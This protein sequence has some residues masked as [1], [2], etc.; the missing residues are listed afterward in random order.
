[1]HARV[2]ARLTV[3]SFH[4]VF[5]FFVEETISQISV[6][7]VSA[8]R[9]DEPSARAWVTRS[10]TSHSHVTSRTDGGLMYPCMPL[11]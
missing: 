1:M 8:G 3:F 6:L 2:C 10:V 7:T 9:D 5:F 4:Q 11:A